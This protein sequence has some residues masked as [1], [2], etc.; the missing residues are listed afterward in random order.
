MRDPKGKTVEDMFPD[1]FYTEEENAETELTDEEIAELQ[2]LVD[3]IN[4]KKE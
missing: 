4:S 3:D 2:G 1:I